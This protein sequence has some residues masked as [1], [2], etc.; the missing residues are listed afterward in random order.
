MPGSLKKKIRFFPVSGSCS[1]DCCFGPVPRHPRHDNFTLLLHLQ[2]L[3][4]F[5]CCCLS[6]VSGVSVC[7]RSFY[8]FQTKWSNGNLAFLVLCVW[9][10]DRFRLNCR[11]CN[12][13]LSNSAHIQA[14][15]KKRKLWEIGQRT[16]QPTS[17]NNAND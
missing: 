2:H 7:G 8:C 15:Q 6:V 4:D 13:V 16:S 14:Q 12:W 10:A 11:T 1:C 9:V 17:L 5:V 3:C